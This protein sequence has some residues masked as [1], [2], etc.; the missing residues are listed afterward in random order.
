M[1]SIEFQF[2]CCIKLA[3]LSVLDV[4]IEKMNFNEPKLFSSGPFCFPQESLDISASLNVS[5]HLIKA[6]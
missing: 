2:G 5:M 4:F 3:E 1:N 6:Q